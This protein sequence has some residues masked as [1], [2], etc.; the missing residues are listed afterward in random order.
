[1]V[2][3]DT[4]LFVVCRSACL[5]WAAKIG[6]FIEKFAFIWETADASP[7]YI[8]SI[9]FMFFVRNCLDVLTRQVKFTALL[10]H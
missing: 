5:D 8:F 7:L 4:I 1:M 10:V 9:V 6:V 3:S 2:C